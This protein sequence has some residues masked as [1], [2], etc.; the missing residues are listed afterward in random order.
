MVTAPPQFYVN[1][2]IPPKFKGQEDT[3][4]A[5]AENFLW[6]WENYADNNLFPSSASKAA[7]FGRCFP[8]RSAASDWYEDLPDAVKSDFETLLDA[9]REKW[10]EDKQDGHKAMTTYEKIDKCRLLD[11][12][13]GKTGVDGKSNHVKYAE[14]MK[15]LFTQLGDLATPQTKAL[16]LANNCGPILRKLILDKVSEFDVK[17]YY[18]FIVN[19]NSADVQTIQ[20]FVHVK[21]QM[22]NSQQPTAKRSNLVQPR[23]AHAVTPSTQTTSDATNRQQRS[24]VGT[25]SDPD[26]KLVP[27]DAVHEVAYLAWE[28]KWSGKPLTRQACLEFPI[29]PGTLPLGSMEC[30]ECG[31]RDPDGH[32]AASCPNLKVRMMEVTVRKFF[33]RMLKDEILKERGMDPE[34][35]RR[36][37]P[38]VSGA[39]RTVQVHFVNDAQDTFAP[40][41]DTNDYVERYYG[42]LGNE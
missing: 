31:N 9:F 18:R 33:A 21:S 22:T 30:W 39:N 8:P 35:I 14:D 15:R 27:T 25:G 7:K 20:Q 36:Y 34:R 41:I 37:T 12:D 6:E 13:V 38:F 42:A 23:S 11:S 10:V 40:E 2:G 5:D 17:Q 1:R 26:R 24:S 19:L 3:D 16:M 29:T 28:R 32:H 4:G